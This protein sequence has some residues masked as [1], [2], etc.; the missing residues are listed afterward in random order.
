MNDTKLT[1]IEER[2]KSTESLIEEALSEIFEIG[3]EL[4]T[5]KLEKGR[6]SPRHRAALDAYRALKKRA[7]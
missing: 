7:L 3:L 4:D 1:Q 5:V 6:V 2:I